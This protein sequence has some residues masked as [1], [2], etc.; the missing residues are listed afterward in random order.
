MSFYRYHRRKRRNNK[1]ST[2]LSKVQI[3][4]GQ[5]IEKYYTPEE[6]FTFDAS[7][8]SI[9]AYDVSCGGT[10]VVIPYEITPADATEAVA[11]TQIGASAFKEKGITSVEFPRSVTT[12]GTT[13]FKK[14]PT[15]EKKCLKM[16]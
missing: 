6:C 7:T 11:V 3:S 13:S 5:G 9:T 1:G 15:L 16:D 14:N 10:D 12:I 4:A 8:G 2:F